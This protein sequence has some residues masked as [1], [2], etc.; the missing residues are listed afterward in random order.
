MHTLEEIRP[1]KLVLVGATSRDRQPGEISLY[2]VDPNESMDKEDVAARLGE[3]VGG[4]ID[5]DHVII[6]NQY[7]GSLPD[8]TVVIDVEAGDQTFGIGYSSEVQDAI[9][10]ILS[11]IREELD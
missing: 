9:P 7:F 6:V 8:D 4:V 5:L 2:R 10:R 11:L 3:S 1:D